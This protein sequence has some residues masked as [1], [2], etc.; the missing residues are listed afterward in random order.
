MTK[1]SGDGSAILYSSYFGGASAEEGNA[2]AVD[3]DGNWYIAGATSSSALPVKLAAQSKY[4]TNR[5]AFVAKFSPDGKTLL[6]STF[7]GGTADDWARG[8]ALDSEANVYVTGYTANNTFPVKN[9]FR[10]FGGGARDAFIAKYK[11][12][13]TLIYSSLLGGANTD[14]GYAVGVDA[15]DDLYVTGFSLSIDFPV[16]SPAQAVITGCKASPCVADLFI[17]KVAADGSQLIY[18]TFYGGTGADQPRAMAVSADGSVFVTG[19]TASTNFPVSSPFQDK[20][21][22]GGAAIGFLLRIN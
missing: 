10:T 5:D 12:D 21:S 4:G 13:G 11:T 22:G 7:L 2:V 18:S 20:N 3:A 19:T 14:E 16:L 6:F 9:P 17:A 8:I 15:N 1:L